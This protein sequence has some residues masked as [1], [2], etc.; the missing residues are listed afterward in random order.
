MRKKEEK[1]MWREK[2]RSKR[3]INQLITWRNEVQKKLYSEAERRKF[4]S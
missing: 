4:T 1:E 2:G 3:K